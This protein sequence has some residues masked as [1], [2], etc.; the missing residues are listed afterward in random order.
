MAHYDSFGGF[1]RLTRAEIINRITVRT[2]FWLSLVDLL[3]WLFHSSRVF[4][5]KTAPSAISVAALLS[6]LIS[7]I[8]MN[9]AMSY[10]RNPYMEGSY[11]WRSGKDMLDA[12]DLLGP[13]PDYSC[14]KHN[15][16]Y[17]GSIG[18]ISAYLICDLHHFDWLH[19]FN[20]ILDFLISIA[21]M[22]TPSP[23]GLP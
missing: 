1:N 2:I 4:H 9:K 15:R 10:G 21:C 11:S 18:L 22:I 19:F 14:Q 6:F 3:S 5:F 17:F 16:L 20:T 13:G 7:A 23:E 12:Y 8:R